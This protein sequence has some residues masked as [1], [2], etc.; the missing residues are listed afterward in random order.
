MYFYLCVFLGEGD[1]V[2]CFQCGGGLTNWKPSEDPWEEH[3][4]WYPG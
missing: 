1:K 3:A 2:K 4:K